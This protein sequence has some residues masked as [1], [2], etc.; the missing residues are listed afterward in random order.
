MGG[1]QGRKEWVL[2]GAGGCPRQGRGW[3]SSVLLQWF[4]LCLPLASGQFEFDLAKSQEG[5]KTRQT[6]GRCLILRLRAQVGGLPCRLPS[7]ASPCLLARLPA[8]RA[9]LPLESPLSCTFNRLLS[10]RPHPIQPAS[11]P[12][13]VSRS[14]HPRVRPS[15]PTTPVHMRRRHRGHVTG[16]ATGGASVECDRA[17]TAQGTTGHDRARQD[18]SWQ[19]QGRLNRPMTLYSHISRINRWHYLLG[20]IQ[21]CPKIG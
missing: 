11:N 18:M 8:C 2:E 14:E 20:L 21:V 1:D 6:G 5:G 10:R 7:A 15:T 19:E 12:K 17:Q 13:T 4:V 9:C 16:T 3:S